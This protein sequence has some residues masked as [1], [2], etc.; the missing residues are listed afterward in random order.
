MAP[1]A[2]S[3]GKSALCPI[4]KRRDKV[5][6]CRGRC[7]ACYRA[8][9]RLVKA[10]KVTWEQLEKAGL[11]SEPVRRRRG[12]FCEAAAKRLKGANL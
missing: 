4:C 9:W 5:T 6:N 12:A 2:K 11:V 10:G 1:R 3:K 8:A 7:A